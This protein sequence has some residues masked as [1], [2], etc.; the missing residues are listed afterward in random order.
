MIVN[1]QIANAMRTRHT[2]RARGPLE[3]RFV[4]VL[5]EP[6]GHGTGQEKKNGPHVCLPRP[7]SYGAPGRRRN[8]RGG[9]TCP[10]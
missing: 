10:A 2:H 4:I 7:A 8:D 5:R 3:E 6:P 1:H 9:A